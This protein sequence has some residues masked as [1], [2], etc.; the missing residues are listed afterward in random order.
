MEAIKK[1]RVVILILLLF[2][3]AVSASCSNGQQGASVKGEKARTTAAVQKKTGGKDKAAMTGKKRT[4]GNKT[5]PME[6]VFKNMKLVEGY[7]NIGEHNPLMTQ[8]FGADPF[9]MKYNGR[10]Y[11]YMTNDDESSKSQNVDFGSI[12]SLSILS[13]SDLVNWRDEGVIQAAGPEGIADW[14]GNSWAPAA[15]HKK[16]NGKEKF[17]LYFA[18]NANGIGVLTSDSPV[19]PWKDPLGKPLISRDT[20][21]VSDV[22]WVFDP[23]VLID[24]SGKAYLYFGGG[25]PK[26]KDAEPDSSRVVQLGKDMTS[27]AGD[28]KVIHAPYMFEDNGINKIGDTY[29]Y[30][31]CSNW[32]ARDNSKGPQPDKATIVYMTSKSPFGP[33]TYKGPILANPGHFFGTYGTNHHDLIQFKGSWYMFYHSQLLDNAMQLSVH[34]FRSTN[35]DAVHVTKDG[36]IGSVTGT[37]A[38]I[39]QIQNLDPY[40]EQEAATMAW[41]GGVSTA[42]ITGMGESYG[43]TRFIDAHLKTGDWLGL[44]KVDFGSDGATSFS[45]KMASKTSGNFMKIALDRADGSAVGY[46]KVP[47]TGST[48]KYEEVTAKIKKI[49]GVHKLFFVFAGKGFQ[50]DSWKFGK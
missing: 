27:L 26:G 12:N 39:K 22:P 13:S 46:V 48:D 19:G 10:V 41:M 6:E 38:G 14:A 47:N 8:R 5:L 37:L 33:W 1:S 44:S 17:F 49:T 7:K 28:P 3:L 31:Y 45:A 25:V 24:D 50:F 35:V 4:N 2:I 42:S 18:N 21:N 23:A 40:T 29:Y 36:A 30:S 20:P 32:S 11:V 43:G 34:G 16:I 9:A 15:V